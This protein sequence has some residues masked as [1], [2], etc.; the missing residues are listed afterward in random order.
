MGPLPD[1]WQ[2]E[3]CPYSHRVRLALTYRGVDFVARQVPA[4]RAER[5]A[6]LAATGHVAIPTFVDVDG[7]V[8]RGGDEILDHLAARYPE[9]DDAVA[10]RAKAVD[11]LPPE[12]RRER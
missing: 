12:W 10:H 2:A 9:R 3:W 4:D 11:D 8:V 7:T 6:M 1:V 5:T